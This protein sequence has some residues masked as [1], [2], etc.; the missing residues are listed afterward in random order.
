M[1]ITDLIPPQDHTLRINDLD[2]HALTWDGG[3]STTVILL[4]G[5]LDLAWSW[6]YTATALCRGRSDLHVVA[7][8]WRGHGSSPRAA[9]GHFYHFVDYVRDLDA[10]VTAVGRDRVFIVGHSMGGGVASLW[11]GARPGR[12]RRAVLIEAGGPRPGGPEDFVSR[13]GDW[14]AQTTPFDPTTLDKP[15]RDLQHVEAR[16]RRN[17]PLLSAERAQFLA[18]KAAV[19]GVDGLWRW[20]YDP[21]NRVRSPTPTLPGVFE[22]FWGRVHIPIVWIEGEVSVLRT[23]TE[24]ERLSSFP[25]LTRRVLPDAGHM[26]QHHQPEA[27]AD[28]VLGMIDFDNEEGVARGNDH[29]R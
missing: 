27:L 28:V 11:L 14:I 4:H 21:L 3:G 12:A 26:V 6:I 16:L 24:A 17:D 20:R 5:Y 8:D 25:N 29:H 13:V 2:L 19:R 9:P 15:M 7:V 22:A 1:T 18:T 23:M 10:V